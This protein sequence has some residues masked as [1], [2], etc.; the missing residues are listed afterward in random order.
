MGEFFLSIILDD[1]LL[2]CYIA[3]LARGLCRTKNLTRMD[4]E[5]TILSTYQNNVRIQ[6]LDRYDNDPGLVM[7]VISSLIPLY[8]VIQLPNNE[9]VYL[10][11]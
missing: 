8:R 10:V 7:L 5:R 2:F 9:L 1:R 6:S 11:K 4:P 3:K